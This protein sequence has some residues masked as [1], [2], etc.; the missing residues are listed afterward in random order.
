MADLY[1]IARFRA[2]ESRA[3]LYKSQR[4]SFYSSII[5]VYYSSLLLYPSQLKVL[6]RN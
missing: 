5:H 3:S 6:C 1:E 2:T 4:L